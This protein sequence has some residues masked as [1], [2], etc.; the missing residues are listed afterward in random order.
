[1]DVFINSK[2][3]EDVFEK[4]IQKNAKVKIAEELNR[5]A[6]NIIMKAMGMTPRTTPDEIKKDLGVMQIVQQR[7]IK[8]GVS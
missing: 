2:P 7:V 5:R 4:Y 1:M 8:S 6:A 3:F